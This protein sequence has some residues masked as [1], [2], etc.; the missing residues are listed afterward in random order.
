MQS[1]QTWLIA[2]DDTF[3]GVCEGLGEDFGFNPNWLR[4]GFA[5]PLLL[6]PVA[7]IALYL[8]VGALVLLTRLIAP[9]PRRAVL[10]EPAVETGEPQ[11]ELALEPATNNDNGE[12]LAAAA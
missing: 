6:N 8:G 5:V 10:A 11:G 7:A 12:E 2:R 3:L 1:T 9:N 4:I